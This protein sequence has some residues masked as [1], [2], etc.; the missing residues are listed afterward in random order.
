MIDLAFVVL[1]YTCVRIYDKVK[2]SSEKAKANV[3]KK[4]SEISTTPVTKGQDQLELPQSTSEEVLLATEEVLPDSDNLFME[5][6]RHYMKASLLT[7][8]SGFIRSLYPI[9]SI[10]IV[11]MLL[12]TY[13]ALPIMRKVEKSVSQSLL[14]KGKIDRFFLVG[15][16]QGLIIGTGHYIIAAFGLT[17][18]HVAEEIIGKI[19]EKSENILKEN[20]FDKMFDP[21]QKVWVVLGDNVEIEIHLSKLK[22]ND[23]VVVKAGEAIPVDGIVTDGMASIDQHA[24]TGESYP[25]EKGKGE[26]VFASTLM[27]TGKLYVQVQKSGRETAISRISQILTDSSISNAEIVLKS[28]KLAE[29]AN[30]PILLLSG[31]VFFV[32]GPTSA[33]VILGSNAIDGVRFFGSLATLNYVALSASKGIMVKQGSVVEQMSSVD[34]ILFDKTGTLT[35]GKLKVSRI[36]ITNFDYT[37]DE[38]LF[39]AAVAEHMLTHPIAKAIL[40]KAKQVNIKLPQLDKTDY[41]F[42]FGIATKF[43][44]KMVRVGSLRFMG[45]EGILIPETIISLQKSIHK[46]G[47]SLVV[48]AIDNEII[49]VVELKA[50]LRNEIKEVIGRL[51]KRGIKHIGIVSGDHPEPTEQLAKWLEVDSYYSEVLAEDKGE[52][53]KK[54]QSQG[55]TVCFVGDGVNDTIAMQ[56]ADVSISLSGA[57]TLA[58]DVAQVV[59]AEPN[60]DYINGLIDLSNGLD[61]NIKRGVGFCL[62]TSASLLTG[63][64]IFNIGILQSIGISFILGI[65]NLGNSM[66]PFFEAKKKKKL[67]NSEISTYALN[68]KSSLQ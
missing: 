23:I 10:A 17:L 29:I 11:N 31:I 35:D 15:A 14:K 47:H 50:S 5:K 67:Q 45:V 52:I 34:T 40:E 1:T 60:L 55:N 21:N 42:G 66:L 65:T 7:M 20:L 33:I 13:S 37:E 9:P 16:G 2:N 26:L 44:N 53:V 24:F 6:R 68:E 30:L 3:N 27:L 59:L 48:V 36:I 8:G 38:L 64:F 4:N 62:L 39:Y 51:K 22:H 46:L 18:S 56:Q 41:R 43:N 25:I 12:Y 57:T 32:I 63:S 54:L 28:E 19:K 58:I 49:G 61:K